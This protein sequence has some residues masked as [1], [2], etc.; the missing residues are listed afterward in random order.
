MTLSTAC[1]ACLISLLTLI[2]RAGV[3]GGT[4]A[5]TIRVLAVRAAARLS[6]R[7]RISERECRRRDQCQSGAEQGKFLFHVFLQRVS[8]VPRKLRPHYCVFSVEQLVELF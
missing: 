3:I 2:E 6:G 1:E 7:R 8:A 4:S 5:R